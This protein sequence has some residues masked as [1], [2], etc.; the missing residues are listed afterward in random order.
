[1]ALSRKK[2]FIIGG[3][4]GVILVGVLAVSMLAS[5]REAPEVT[6]AEVKQQPKLESKVTASGEVRPVKF[7]NLTA[8]V[9][10]RITNLYVKEGD[11][12]KKGQPLI[13]VDPTQLAEQVA[14]SAANV[15]AAIADATASQA[16]VNS[17][18]N[19]VYTSEASLSSAQAD[20][21]RARADLSLAEANLKRNQQLLDSGVISKAAYDQVDNVFRTSQAAFNGAKARVEQLKTQ[22][23]E[24]RIR[25]KQSEANLKSSE[26]RTN[27]I[28][29]GLR[30]NQDL[31]YKTTRFSPIDGVVSSL[32]VKEGEFALANFSSTP[33]M[34]IADLSEVNV[35]VK[36]D[37][38]DIANVRVGQKAKIKVDALGDTEID[39]EVTEVG[40]SAITRSGQTIATSTGS[41]EAKDFKVVVRLLPN[42][43]TRNKL[44]PGMSATAVVTTDSRENAVVV[45]LQALVLQEEPVPADAPKDGPVQKPKEVQGVFILDGNKVKF[46]A[47]ETGI[48]GDTDIEVKNGVTVGQKIVTGPF[49][50]LRTLKN[51]TVVKQAVDKPGGAEADK[52][53][54]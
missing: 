22:V 4:I 49:S 37:E 2:K 54:S 13:K 47:V 34:V 28:R 26:A 24:A 42:D 43:E 29:A 8:E 20:L 11:D 36:V 46:T 33:L 7:Y 38:T 15:N 16:A 45:P 35:E 30:S 10:G 27:Q 31:L 53:K 12:V 19:N 25:V 50:V 9:S 14:G 40:S 6:V 48:T 1:M 17:A 39:G 3:V 44:R 21:E 5:N 52:K 41:Q 32:P 23:E 18:Q 51:D